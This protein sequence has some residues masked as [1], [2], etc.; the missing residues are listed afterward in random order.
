M[1]ESSDEAA[2]YRR[3]LREVEAERDRLAAQVEHLQRGIVEGLLDME[4]VGLDALTA[5]GSELADL[6]DDNGLPDAHKV[7]QA[8]QDARVA[9]GIPGPLY[10][11]AEGP[12]PARGRPGGFKAAFTDQQSPYRKA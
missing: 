9:L 3:R 7:R 4:A 8:A 6:L 10:V 11:P 5:T 12:I 2:R 1:S